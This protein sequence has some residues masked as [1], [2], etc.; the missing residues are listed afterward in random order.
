[1]RFDEHVTCLCKK[2]SQKLHA[3][4]R[5]SKFM[6]IEQRKKIM[7]A[8]ISSQFGYCPLIWMFHSRRLNNRINKIHERALRLVY[9]DDHL[10]FEQLLHMDGSCTIHERNIQILAIEL[11]KIINGISLTMM[12]KVLPLKDSANR[13]CSRFPF[14]TR[15]VHTVSYGTETISFLG[16]KIW[17]IIPKI[18]KD[19]T[20][21]NEFKSRIKKWKPTLCPCR[22]C[23]TFIA[24]IGFVNIS[25]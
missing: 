4:A 3:L 5:V 7:N 25:M 19:S 18:I 20:T 10:T 13:Y 21:R 9:Q 6:N 11:Y 12:K 14:E 23:K 17:H 1:M 15:N 24:G 8:F 22:L 16:P 2:A